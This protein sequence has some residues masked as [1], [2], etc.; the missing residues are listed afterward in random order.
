MSLSVCRPVPPLPA[1][2]HAV[3][4]PACHVLL[5]LLLTHCQMSCPCLTEGRRCHCHSM[6]L[7]HMP[8]IV[9][10]EMVAG[11]GRERTAHIERE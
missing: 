3:S 2:F 10:E 4:N 9:R 1:L 8:E 6:S 7:P 11:T 5:M